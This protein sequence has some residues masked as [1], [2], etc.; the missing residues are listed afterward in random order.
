MERI[1]EVGQV[2][3]DDVHRHRHGLEEVTLDRVHALG[4]AVAA[5]VRLRERD[6]FRV[7]VDGPDLDPWMPCRE[8]DG[9]HAAAG[10]DVRHE[11][12]LV[13]DQFPGHANDP[14]RRGPRREH[15]SGREREGEVVE[16]RFHGLKLPWC[17]TGGN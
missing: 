14:L 12:R 1:R 11:L 6:G 2:R 8:R 5:R 16:R 15:A 7:L 13:A 4:D 3:D 17:P 9:D 10:P